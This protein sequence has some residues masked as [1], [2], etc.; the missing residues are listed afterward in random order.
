MPAGKG[1]RSLPPAA[2]QRRAVEVLALLQ[3]QQGVPTWFQRYDPVT[4]LVFTILSQHTSDVNSERAGHILKATFPSWDAIADADPAEVEKA[5]RSAGLAKQKVPRIQETLKKVRELTGDY[6]LAFLKEMPLADAK[7]WLKALP[8]VGPKTAAIVLSFS[9][10]LPAMAVDVH[11]F[12]VTGRL[13]LIGPKINVDKAHDVLEAFLPP[14]DI[15]GFHV[16]LIAHGRQVCKA[17]RPLCGECVLRDACLG[18]RE[19]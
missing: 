19:G 5:V 11:V 10:G 4:E 9:L 16:A 12:R 14:D 1:R 8:G 15:Y 17:L 2:A 6:D 13:G 3:K 7:R 18:R